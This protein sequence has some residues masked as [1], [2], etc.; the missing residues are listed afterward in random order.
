MK[1]K[2]AFINLGL[3]LAVLFAVCYQSLHAFSHSLEN[4]LEHKHSKSD[5][6]LVHEISE[7]EDCPVC[8]F[9]FVA[10]LSP[11]IFIFEFNHLYKKVTYL[12]SIPEKINAFNGSLYSLRGPPCFI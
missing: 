11:E 4:D 7:I 3:M 9:K 5:K 10:F 1:K 12:F 6:N 2:Y 8:D